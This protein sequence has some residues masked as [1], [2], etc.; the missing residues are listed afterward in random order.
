[1][2]QVRLESPWPL[3]PMGSTQQLA[4]PIVAI[5]KSG[6]TVVHAGCHW[7]ITS[8]RWVVEVVLERAPQRNHVGLFELMSMDA[9]SRSMEIAMLLLAFYQPITLVRT[10]QADLGM[11]SVR[12]RVHL[13]PMQVKALHGYLIEDV[14]DHVSW[15]KVRPNQ[16][17]S[18]GSAEQTTLREAASKCLLADLI[19]EKGALPPTDEWRSVIR[20]G[21]GGT[22]EGRPGLQAM[23]ATRAPQ[24]EG[25]A[26]AVHDLEQFVEGDRSQS[27]GQRD[28]LASA[29]RQ[30]ES[31]A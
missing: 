19:L 26:W 24:M 4:A 3:R 6:S 25:L 30:S 29:N 13:S 18:P 20:G 17:L 15:I 14:R 21:R 1:M 16:V 7:S 28:P 2:T 22:L 23:L 31:Q 11:E 27:V 10:D 9:G 8:H 5:E 12:S